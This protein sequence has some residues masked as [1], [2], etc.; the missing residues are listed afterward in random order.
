MQPCLWNWN[1]S[2]IFNVYAKRHKGTLNRARYEKFLVH[3]A[4]CANCR[5]KLQDLQAAEE[6]ENSRPKPVKPV[7]PRKEQHR[8]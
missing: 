7:F 2:K 1:I 3:K 4:S 5:T 8:R 6:L